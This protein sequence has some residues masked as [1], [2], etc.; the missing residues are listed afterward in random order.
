[1]KKYDIICI[2]LGISGLYF[3]YKCRKYDKN[4]LFLEKNNHIGGRTKSIDIGD[5]YTAEGCAAR[6]F[7]TYEM[8][9]TLMNDYYLTKLI[10]EL[11]MEYIDMPNTIASNNDYVNIINKINNIYPLKDDN[12]NRMAKKALTTI[13]EYLGYSIN[14]FSKQIGYELFNSPINLHM[15]MSTIN[16]FESSTQNI[17]VEGF[18][19]LC[20][21]LYRKIKNKCSYKFK[22]NYIV[23]NIEYCDGYY[24]INN[25]Y[26]TKKLVFTGT[27][28]Q[29]LRININVDHLINLKNDLINNYFNY[30]GIRIYLQID[31]PW[32][33]NHDYFNKWNSFEPY[34][35]IIYYS[36]NIINIYTSM[37]TAEMLYN[38]IPSKYKKIK[39]FI[40]VYKVKS[41]TKYLVCKLNKFFNKDIKASKIWYKYTNDA[42]QFVKPIHS[43]YRTFL[44]N[45][46][47][48]NNFYMMSGDYTHNPGW[49]NSCLYIVDNNYKQIID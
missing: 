9:K 33:D 21:N 11:N 32:W 6:F 29:L 41:F 36:K 10:N 15:A 18:E 44:R 8:D 31:N 1:M 46:E 5:E 20:N 37:D 26:K 24:I 25:C 35:Q 3:G 49:I 4:I 47:R 22:L 23:N 48:N 45:I 13:V 28:D 42:A 43:D 19:E 17:L 12:I 2:G 16:K 7:A 27:K 38:M 39:N 40:H 14:I 34:G 30:Q